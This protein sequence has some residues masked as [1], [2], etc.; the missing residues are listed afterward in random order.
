MGFWWV[1]KR[2]RG[3]QKTYLPDFVVRETTV[4][5]WRILGKNIRLVKDDIIVLGE[6]GVYIIYIYIKLNYIHLFICMQNSPMKT[7]QSIIWGEG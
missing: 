5:C 4:C 3:K 1:E 2:E 6:K 7:K